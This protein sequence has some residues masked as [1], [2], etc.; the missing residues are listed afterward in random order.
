M[1]TGTKKNGQEIVYIAT[2]IW[3]A[4]C[5]NVSSGICEQWRPS[6][7]C[8]FAHSDQGFPCPLTESF[9]TAE[10]IHWEERPWWYFAH[11]HLAHVR[12]HVF[13]WLGPFNFQFASTSSCSFL[14]NVTINWFYAHLKYTEASEGKIF[15]TLTGRWQEKIGCYEEDMKIKFAYR[16]M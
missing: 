2:I 16:L 14:S 9:D 11:A 8:A 10:C 5:E 3:S 6:S 4:P 15:W 12:R 1:S 13:A 7:A